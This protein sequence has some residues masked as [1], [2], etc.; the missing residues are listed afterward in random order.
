MLRPTP[1]AALWITLALVLFV[2]GTTSIAH[3]APMLTAALPRCFPFPPVRPA[4]PRVRVSAPRVRRSASTTSSAWCSS[5]PSATSA[6]APC[7]RS[8]CSTASRAPRRRCAAQSRV[9]WSR[10]ELSRAGALP[11][12]P[13]TALHLRPPRLTLPLS[14]ALLS[15]SPCSRRKS[16]RRR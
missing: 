6:T 15:R 8:S 1:R 16:C 3:L 9:E 13:R 4:S 2:S 10:A 14:S 7:R 11:T 5:S 12:S